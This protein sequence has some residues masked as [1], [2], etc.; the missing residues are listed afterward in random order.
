M[1]ALHMNHDLTQSSG[2]SP[3]R[4]KMIFVWIWVLIIGQGI[5]TIAGREMWPFSPYPMYARIR[6]QGEALEEVE[7]Y[8]VFVENGVEREEQMHSAILR[9]RG[10]QIL[11]DN[12]KVQPDGSKLDFKQRKAI[13]D[14]YLRNDLW[15]PFRSPEHAERQAGLV[16]M[17]AYLLTYNNDDSFDPT[18]PSKKELLGETMRGRLKPATTRKAGK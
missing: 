18:K 11:R 5:S 16:G 4:R 14:E 9:T 3:G 12:R 8:K 1:E 13:W 17:R 7:M 10:R 6:Y 15:H 2:M